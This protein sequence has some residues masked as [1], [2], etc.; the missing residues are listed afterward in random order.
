MHARVAP[1]GSLF[2]FMEYGDPAA[3]TDLILVDRAPQ[4]QETPVYLCGRECP[5]EHGSG[6]R[7]IRKEQ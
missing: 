3:Y 1:D 6:I 4:P 2:D 5:E 7:H